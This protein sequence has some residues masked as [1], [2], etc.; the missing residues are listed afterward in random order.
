MLSKKNIIRM[1]VF[2][3]L[4]GIAGWSYYYFIGCNNGCAIQSNA[5][6]MT[7]YGAFTGGI[8]GIPSQKKK[9]SVKE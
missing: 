7:L 4:G 3:L 5:T 2:T 8:L 9:E 6:L 1:S